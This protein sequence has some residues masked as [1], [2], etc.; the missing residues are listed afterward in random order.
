MMVKSIHITGLKDMYVA[1]D[2]GGGVDY[3]LSQEHGHFD[4]E[5]FAKN[6]PGIHQPVCSKAL[7]IL[8]F[9]GKDRVD[10]GTLSPHT[11]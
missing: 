10:V 4:T 9:G 3:A 11:V 8:T 1:R 5:N 2:R 6:K 7:A